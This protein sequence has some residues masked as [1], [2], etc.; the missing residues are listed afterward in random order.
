MTKE[1]VITVPDN[2]NPRKGFNSHTMFNCE[3]CEFHTPDSAI[4][5]K[6]MMDHV[7]QEEEPETLTTAP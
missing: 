7:L 3:K 4:Y 2:F 5:V 1:I 6:H